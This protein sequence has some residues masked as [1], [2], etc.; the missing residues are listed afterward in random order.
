[1][2]F[3]MAFALLFTIPSTAMAQSGPPQYVRDAVDGTLSMLRGQDA[4]AAATYVDNIMADVS[5]ADREA[6]IAKVESI[7]S[8]IGQFPDGVDVEGRPGG[9]TLMLQTGD[10]AKELHLEISTEGVTAIRLD[11]EKGA[12][13]SAAATHDARVE[14]HIRALE[15]LHRMDWNEFVANHLS[16]NYRSTLG[17]QALARLREQLTQAAAS[18][19]GAG[20]N[21]QGDLYVLTLSSPDASWEI[22]FAV[23]SAAP[24]GIRSLRIADANADSSVP[25]ITR[26]NI[27]EV[28]ANI[29]E[30]GFD[31]VVYVKVGGEELVKRPLGF[32]DR[33][34][35]R[36]MTYNKIFG[37]GSQP[38]D[39]TIALAY[40][41][42]AEGHL[43]L[44]DPISNYV[45]GVPVDKS[46]MTLRHL[47]QSTS[48]LPDFLDNEDDWDPDLSWITRDEL[49]RRVLAAPLKGAPG[50]RHF[51][52]HAGYSFLASL[53]E[54]AVGK[55]YYEY[56]KEKILDPAGMKHTGMYGDSLG[57]RIEDF[58]V[59]GGPSLVGLPNIPPNWG[60]TS[61]LVKG[62]GGMFST[63]DDINRFAD[64]ITSSRSLPAEVRDHFSRETVNF[65]G[66]LRGF[67]MFELRSGRDVVFVLSNSAMQNRLYRDLAR[68]LEQFWRK[69]AASR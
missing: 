13:V 46:A 63:M 39:Y 53:I 58:A 35:N 5:P 52:S 30:Q 40:I 48:G 43:S 31:G 29:E 47:L 65:N 67:E 68:R 21:V 33:A 64:F 59:G 25:E 16:A 11:E 15:R 9:V 1:M 20:I 36:P 6:T 4:D 23:E 66:S 60:P 7:K 38:I 44:D 49:A 34:F 57:Y 55:P 27:H 42:Q 12:A 69:D 50:S 45:D 24:Y 32:A 22:S 41:A 10:G 8:Q 17:Q 62:S 3:A 28:L 37:T 61:W 51:H 26:G 54:I 18:A 2:A 56:L 19:Q 14:Q